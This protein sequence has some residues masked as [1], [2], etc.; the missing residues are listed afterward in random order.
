MK[1]KVNLDEWDPPFKF[2][3]EHASNQTAEEIHKENRKNAPVTSYY[4]WV[5]FVM[6]IQAGIF[7]LPHKVT[8]NLWLT[9]INLFPLDLVSCWGWASGVLWNRRKE[10][11]AHFVG[12]G[13]WLKHHNKKLKSHELIQNDWTYFLQILLRKKKGYEGDDVVMEDVVEKFV[14]YFKSILHHNNWYFAY[15]VGCK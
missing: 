10:E 7:Y 3:Y 9:L 12:F 1:C 8:G 4:Q 14:E 2:Y 13:I 15:F 6:A 11:G 5:T